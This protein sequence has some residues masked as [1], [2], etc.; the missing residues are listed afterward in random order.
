[1]HISKNP[2]FLSLLSL[3]TVVGNRLSVFVERR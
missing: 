3:K 2:L 1:M